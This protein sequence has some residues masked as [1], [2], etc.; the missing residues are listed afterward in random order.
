MRNR[1]GTLLQVLNRA[2]PEPIE[3]KAKKLMSGKTFIRA[4]APL[5]RGG[6]GRGG[7]GRAVAP[8]GA[9]PAAGRSAPAGRAG[10]TAP[11]RR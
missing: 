1:V 3:K 2:R 11:P 10:P 7:A 6:A 9:S 5:P 8:A 4:D